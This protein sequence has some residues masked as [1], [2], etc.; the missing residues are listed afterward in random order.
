M[1]DVEAVNETDLDAYVDNQ[2]DTP[3]RLRVENHL[4]RHPDVAARVMADLGMRTTLKLALQTEQTNSSPATREAARRLTASLEG[5]RMWT[6]LQR[7]AAIAVLISIGWFANS[8]IGPFGPSEVNASTHPPAFVEQALRAHQTSLVREAMPS[9]PEV[10][11]YDREEI[12]AATAI[13]MPKLPKDWQ[14]VDVQIFPSDFGPSVEA[15]I[16]K[17]G[18]RL[19]LFAVRPGH[20]GVEPVKDL[21]MSNAEAAWWQIGEIAYALVSSNPEAGLSDEAELLKN[22]LH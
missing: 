22:S 17:D 7:I 12:R 4:A 8:S 21:K 9:Q 6:S 3:A 1:T 19:S 20:F 13:L 2:L 18:M 5:R 15:T 11:T 10:K 16:E 14:V